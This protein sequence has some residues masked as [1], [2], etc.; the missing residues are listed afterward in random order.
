MIGN[1]GNRIFSPFGVMKSKVE[2]DTGDIGSGCL[3]GKGQWYHLNANVKY[4]PIHYTSKYEK[5]ENQ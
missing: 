2:A 4:H 3:D 5:Q 1:I